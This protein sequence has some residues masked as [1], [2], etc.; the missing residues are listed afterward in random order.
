MIAPVY[1]LDLEDDD[2]AEQ[3]IEC[4]NEPEFRAYYLLTHL[5]QEKHVMEDVLNVRPNVY[6]SPEYQLA[7]EVG[8]Q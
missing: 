6:H 8:H 5:T 3:G 7:L 1:F 4:G 2:L